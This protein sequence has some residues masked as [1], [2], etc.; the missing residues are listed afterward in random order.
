[1]AGIEV[2]C[3][4]FCGGLAVR[5]LVVIGLSDVQ[6]IVKFKSLQCSSP[7]LLFVF[8]PQHFALV[9]DLLSCCCGASCR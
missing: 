4:Y 1:M 5:R 8:Y 7:L 3:C 9:V 2:I 6:V